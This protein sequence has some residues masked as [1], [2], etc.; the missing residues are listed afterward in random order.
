MEPCCAAD[1]APG[2]QAFFGKGRFEGRTGSFPLFALTGLGFNESPPL[3]ASDHELMFGL[4][5]ELES[6]YLEREGH[7]LQKFSDVL[8]SMEEFL[9]P[10]F[11]VLSSP[12]ARYLPW[13]DGSQRPRAEAAERE[14]GA[15]YISEPQRAWVSSPKLALS[16]GQRG[17]SPSLRP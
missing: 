11:P 3:D 14:G 13:A 4:R 9:Q 6:A 7:S 8:A 5:Q 17:G 12:E 16:S 10:L 2:H 1:W 15:G